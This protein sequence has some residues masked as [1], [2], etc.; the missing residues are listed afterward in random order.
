MTIKEKI[1]QLHQWIYDKTTL[2][3]SFKNSLRNGEVGSILYTAG[4]E[5]VN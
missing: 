2:T 3:D 5:V 1:G 4:C